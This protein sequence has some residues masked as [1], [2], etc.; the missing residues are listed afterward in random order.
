[1][2][3]V[4]VR[5]TVLAGK[6][7]EL[8]TVFSLLQNHVVAEDG[9]EQYEAFIDGETFII[10]E[11]WASGA[12]LDTHLKQAHMA[13]YIPAIKDCLEGGALHVQILQVESLNAVTL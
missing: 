2:V 7:E 3:V 4:L 8:R 11:R 5:A 9:C 12:A 6:Q 1:M 13:Q 10:Q